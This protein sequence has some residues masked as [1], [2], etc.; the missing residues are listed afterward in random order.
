[1]C[2]LRYRNGQVTG[3]ARIVFMVLI[4]VFGFGYCCSVDHIIVFILLHMLRHLVNRFE[5]ELHEID[6]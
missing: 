5:I 6:P 1:M 3:I 4:E 2:C